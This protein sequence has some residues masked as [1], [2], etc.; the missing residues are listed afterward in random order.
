MFIKKI[1][2]VF[3]VAESA[4]LGVRAP[5]N[6]WGDKI[7]IRVRALTVMDF[8]SHALTGLTHERVATV[9]KRCKDQDGVMDLSF[10]R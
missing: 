9:N 7:R 5:Q 1:S 6:S 8:E 10:L 4:F 3:R 2:Q